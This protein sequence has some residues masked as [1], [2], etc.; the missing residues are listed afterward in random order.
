MSQT[1]MQSEIDNVRSGQLST[2]ELRKKLTHS[3]PLIRANA[4]GVLCTLIDS[5]SSLVH[6]IVRFAKHSDQ[7]FV[8][9]GAVTVGHVALLSLLQSDSLAAQSAGYEIVSSYAESDRE[10]LIYFLKS[11][12]VDFAKLKRELIMVA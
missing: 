1:T 8:L 5:E 10:D 4:V 11:E 9:M 7:R 3:S 12:G 2:E 6:E